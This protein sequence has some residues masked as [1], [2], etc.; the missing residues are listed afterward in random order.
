MNV[1]SKFSIKISLLVCICVTAILCSVNGQNGIQNLGGANSAALAGSGT[2]LADIT[3]VYTNQAG[4]AFLKSHAAD[5]SIDRRFNIAELTTYSA[6]FAYKMN[7]A[8]IGIQVGQYGFDDYA[9]QKIGLSY[10][11]LISK[12]V[13]LSAQL[14]LLGW[15]IE[16]FGNTYKATAEF[17]MYAQ[18]SRKFHFGA[19]IF[20]PGQIALTENENIDSRFKLGTRYL[21][22]DKVDIFLEA[23]KIIDRDIQLK[24]ATRYQYRDYLDI[25]LGANLNI[26][27]LHFGFKYTYKDR[28]AVSFS[29]ALNNN[30]IGNST[31]FSGQ[32]YHLP[33][34]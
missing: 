22:S 21:P 18:V 24:L 8:A 34:A 5:L 27:S 4:L 28:M 15:K 9:E 11:R 30:Q 20:N 3:S 26:E 12:N 17:G 2:C 14:D 19:H 1:I 6:G 13:S 23:E 25:M 10:A 29:F 16:G 32:Y 33:K 31:A 7:K